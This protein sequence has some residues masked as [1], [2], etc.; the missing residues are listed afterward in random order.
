MHL[1]LTAI[2]FIS[3]LLYQYKYILYVVKFLIVRSTSLFFVPH[4]V[5]VLLVRRCFN[6]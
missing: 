2:V 1:C 4:M 6:S 3:L 5:V